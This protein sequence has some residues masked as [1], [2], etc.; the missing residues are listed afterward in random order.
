M[1]PM[2]PWYRGFTGTIEPKAGESKLFVSRQGST[3]GTERTAW[4]SS[5]RADSSSY[6]VSGTFR[7]VDETT[8]EITEL[9]VK[10]W[11]QVRPARDNA[12]SSR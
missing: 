10:R 12:G 2:H 1:E 11:T 6:V 9:P 4:L 7:R 8:I 3:M 5:G